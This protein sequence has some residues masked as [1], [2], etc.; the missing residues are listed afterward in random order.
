M[1]MVYAF[2]HDSRWSLSLVTEFLM[3]HDCES[4]EGLYLLQ[5]HMPIER[6]K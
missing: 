3:L 6:Y 5:D 2:I 4:S 1:S